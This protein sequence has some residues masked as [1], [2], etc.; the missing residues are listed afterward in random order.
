MAK[1]LRWVKASER[2]PEQQK[3]DRPI[4]ADYGY[5]IGWYD[6]AAAK[7]FTDSD[8]SFKNDDV[9]WLEETEEDGWVSVA[10][11]LPKLSPSYKEDGVTFTPVVE[12]CLVFDGENVYEDTYDKDGFDNKRVTHWRP[13]PSPPKP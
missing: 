3:Q 12:S 10:K 4:R 13:L 7:W 9:E 5:C 11:E 2:L 8:L 1:T 6:D